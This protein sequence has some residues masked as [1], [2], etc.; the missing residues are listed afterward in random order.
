MP[1]VATAHVHARSREKQRR[2]YWFLGD[3]VIVHLSGED[4]GG[5]FSLL[6]FLQPPDYMTPLHVHRGADQAFYVLEGE[7]TLHLPGQSV[8]AGPG[9]SAYGP[10]NVPHADHTTSADPARFLIVNSPAGFEAFVAAAGEPAAELTLP[11]PPEEPP[12]IERLAAL[13]AE[14]DIELLGAPGNLP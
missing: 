14:H 12:D 3:L 11:P 10:I 9:G 8:A 7:L 6:E 1:A 13:A 5:R 2:A 4:T